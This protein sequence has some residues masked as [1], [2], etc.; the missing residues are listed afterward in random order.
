MDVIFKRFPAVR[1]MVLKNLDNQSI[2]RSVKANRGFAEILVKER[3]YWIRII[4]KYVGNFKGVKESW[5]EVL[6]RTPVEVIK[7]LALTVEKLFKFYIVKEISP[8]YVGFALNGCLNIC[9]LITEKTWNIMYSN[10]FGLTPLH[11]AANN[12]D[13]DIFKFI[14]GRVRDKNPADIDGYTP[15]HLAAVQGMN[16]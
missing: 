11:F 1:R 15:F 3:L 7:E 13:L 16:H 10:I 2:V 12:G 8:F 9:K 6:H 5:K 14:I 4:K